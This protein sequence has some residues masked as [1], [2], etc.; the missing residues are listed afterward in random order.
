MVSRYSDWARAYPNVIVTETL[1]AGK[2]VRMSPGTGALLLTE[3]GVMPTRLWLSSSA[4]CDKSISMATRRISDTFTLTNV[5][6]KSYVS[7]KE[8]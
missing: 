8:S 3:A 4:L 1:R 5:S 6:L 2:S 7:A